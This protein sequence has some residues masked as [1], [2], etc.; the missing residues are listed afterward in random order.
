M[1]EA[2]RA[3]VVDDDQD[4][5]ET[6]SDVLALDGWTVDQ[7]ADGREALAILR[8]PARPRPRLILLDVMMPIMNGWQFLDAKRS[9]EALAAITVVLMTASSVDESKRDRDGYEAWLRKPFQLDELIAL[10][11]SLTGRTAERA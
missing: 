11:Q 2:K 3:L 10:L 9:D 4:L 7:A 1:T 5:R 8:E 6:V